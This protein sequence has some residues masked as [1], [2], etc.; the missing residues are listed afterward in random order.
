MAKKT[1]YEKLKDPRWQKKRLEVMQQNDFSCEIC[2]DGDNT[3][4]VHHKEYF[5]DLEPWDYDVS[6][7]ACLCE[8]CHENSHDELDV[9]KWVCSLLKLDGDNNRVE[10]AYL[11]A[12]YTG[13]EYES[14]LSVTCMRDD[15]SLRNPYKAGVEARAI[16]KY[17]LRSDF[18]NETKSHHEENVNYA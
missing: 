7:L 8:S 11:I 5:K 16:S 14:I 1:Y 10:I 12:G 17:G 3:L 18:F 15:R 2:G 13:I 9:L 4:N 6:Q